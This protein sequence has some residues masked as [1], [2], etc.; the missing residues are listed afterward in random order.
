MD[1]HQHP[2]CSAIP[3]D[4]P[5]ILCIYTNTVIPVANAPAIPDDPDPDIPVF[6]L[7]TDV[8]ISILSRISGPSSLPEFDI[9]MIFGTSSMLRNLGRYPYQYLYIREYSHPG[10]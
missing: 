9:S 5:I 6:K 10:G 2:K 1:I 7:K 3:A 8:M 4:I